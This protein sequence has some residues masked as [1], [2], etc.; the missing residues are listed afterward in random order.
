MASTKYRERAGAQRGLSPNGYETAFLTT[1]N[2]YRWTASHGGL[3]IWFAGSVALIPPYLTAVTPLQAYQAGNWFN[4]PRST[5]PIF[6]GALVYWY[7]SFIW[8]VQS[9]SSN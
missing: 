7:S 3:G 1:G 5:I 2:A 8:E 6:G 9:W 4:D